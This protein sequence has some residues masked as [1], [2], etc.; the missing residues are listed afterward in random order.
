MS[1][2]A[3]IR[4]TMRG[5]MWGLAARIIM[6]WSGSSKCDTTALYAC[7]IRKFSFYFIKFSFVFPESKMNRRLLFLIFSILLW[8]S[9][10]IGCA[11]SP[12]T[13]DGALTA[14]EARVPVYFDK[15]PANSPY[16]FTTLKPLP[17]EVVEQYVQF[18]SMVGKQLDGIDGFNPQSADTAERFAA[19]LFGEIAAADGIEGLEQLGFSSAPQAAI[20]GIG[21]FPVMRVTLGDTEA[22]SALLD[23]V[24]QK[25]GLVPQMRARSEEHTSELQSRPH[26]VCR[27]LL[28]K[29]KK[30]NNMTQTQA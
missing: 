15:I 2:R 8:A 26:L 29:K 19:A 30:K 1:T 4:S 28:E 17:R 16:V 20:Y 9:F 27:L 13:K 11:S 25:S 23:R 24:E 10:C 12:D 22:F 3:C 5:R 14:D 6:R 7:V 21:W 18:S